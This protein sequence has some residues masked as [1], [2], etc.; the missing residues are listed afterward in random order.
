MKIM[1]LPP[2]GEKVFIIETR[3]GRFA[4]VLGGCIIVI[5]WELIRDLFQWLMEKV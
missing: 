4:W 5:A 3:P 1:Y 2:F